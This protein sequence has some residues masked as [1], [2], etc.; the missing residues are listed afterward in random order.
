MWID[1]GG[2]TLLAAK[3]RLLNLLPHR[4]QRSAE[5]NNLTRNFLYLQRLVRQGI[6]VD[7]QK[8][9]FILLDDFRKQSHIFMVTLQHTSVKLALA[10]IIQMRKG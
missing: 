7:F 4:S 3:A 2:G 1:I 8:K 10:A 5:L 9:V 6:S